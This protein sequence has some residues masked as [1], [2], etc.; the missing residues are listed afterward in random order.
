MLLHT[1]IS[2][3]SIE[4]NGMVRTRLEDEGTTKVDVPAVASGL[5]TLLRLHQRT[6]D[7]C[8]GLADAFERAELEG[9]DD[10]RRRRTTIV[11]CLTTS[12]NGGATE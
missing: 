5:N 3:H 11:V 12:S 1:D 9:H 4:K 2:L 10:K 8:S 6:D 7:E